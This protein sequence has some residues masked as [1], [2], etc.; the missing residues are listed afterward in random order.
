MNQGTCGRI[1]NAQYRKD[2]RQKV[3]AHREADGP[4][5]GLYGGIS[6]PF[7]VRYPGEKELLQH[8]SPGDQP[9]LLHVD[10]ICLKN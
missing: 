8:H 6:K 10:A 5:D 2:N 4:F 1:Q 9:L 3:N 7:K